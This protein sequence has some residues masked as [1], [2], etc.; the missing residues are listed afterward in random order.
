VPRTRGN[1]E[2][3][4]TFVLSI[5][6][7]P[8][9]I[10]NI[11]PV[12]ITLPDGTYIFFDQD[13]IDYTL[14]KVLGR[15]VRLTR[16]SSL[17]KPRYEEYWRD[18]DGLAQRKKVTE[19]TMPSQTFFDSAG[20]HLLTTSTINRLR[21][22]YPGPFEVRRFR[23]NVVMESA[24]GEKDFIENL[25]RGKKITTGEDIV[26]RVTGPCTRCVMISLPQGDLPQ[27]L[28]ILHTVARYNQVNMGV[29]ASVHHVGTIRHGDLV[30]L[31]G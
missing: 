9:A 12:R 29:Y 5:I 18:I 31:E 22:L 3:S 21:E 19:E 4:S 16:A 27:D 28:G 24:S 17:H 10:E 20:I 7:P 25:W 8:Q 30:Q 23:P 14:S 6:D 1:G 11:P 2:S 13:D 26:I 15:D